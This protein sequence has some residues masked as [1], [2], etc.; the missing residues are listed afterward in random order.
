[1][2]RIIVISGFL[3]AFIAGAISGIAWTHHPRGGPQNDRPSRE[4]WIASELSLTTEQ[5]SQM[6]DIWSDMNAGHGDW[7]GKRDQLRRQRDDAIAALIP[8]DDK[9]AFDA[10][11]QKYRQQQDELDAEGRKR[12]EI[13][14]EKTKKILTDEQLKK[15]E[16]LLAR[17]P[18]TGRGRDRPSS[19]PTTQK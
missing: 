13:A 10:I 12:F 14:V 5:Q 15:Y 8:A 2:T 3:I 6:K 9:P 11:Q 16:Q 18:G 7:R 4:S 1:M 19:R 17:G